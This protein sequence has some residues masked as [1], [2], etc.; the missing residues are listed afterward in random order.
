MTRRAQ[1]VHLHISGLLLCVH[2]A[3]CS[4]LLF[5]FLMQCYTKGHYEIC[6]L[7]ITLQIQWLCAN[8]LIIQIDMKECTKKLLVFNS[9]VS[10]N[11]PINN[12]SICLTPQVRDLLRET[13]AY[14]TPSRFS[15]TGT[16]YTFPPHWL[17]ICLKFNEILALPVTIV[18]VHILHIDDTIKGNTIKGNTLI[19]CCILGEST[20][21][22][23]SL[24]CKRMM[25]I[26]LD[27]QTLPY[28]V[29]SYYVCQSVDSSVAVGSMIH[30]HEKSG[31]KAAQK[32]HSL[33]ST[34][35]A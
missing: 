27:F 11:H 18:Y 8:R 17:L 10:V 19:N 9:F 21:S 13:Y 20:V 5:N 24:L 28:Q 12:A 34:S 31:V 14:T 33:T 35:S 32:C 1:L 4:V 22:V 26:T 2:C 15:G 16:I 29:C 25:F 3:C 23:V 7:T 30:N 6:C